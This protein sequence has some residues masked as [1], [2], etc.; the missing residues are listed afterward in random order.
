MRLI[1][2]KLNIK[3]RHIV[4]LSFLTCDS[5]NIKPQ[6]TFLFIGKYNKATSL[7]EIERCEIFLLKEIPEI[8]EYEKSSSIYTLIRQS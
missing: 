7:C 1:Y 5:L 4:A 2:L 6:R 8:K 3:F